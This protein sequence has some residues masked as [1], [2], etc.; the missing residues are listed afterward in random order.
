M[1]NLWT[2]ENLVELSETMT[3]IKKIRIMTYQNKNKN[4]GLQSYVEIQ[5]EKFDYSKFLENH[6]SPGW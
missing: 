3:W 1:R 6:S 2:V 4:K 5:L